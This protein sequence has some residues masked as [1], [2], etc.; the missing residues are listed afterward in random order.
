MEKKIKIKWCNR[1]SS[2]IEDDDMGRWAR[3]AYAGKLD[4]F[5]FYRNR[6]SY[7]EIAWISKLRYKNKIKFLITYRFPQ[8]DNQYTFDNLNDAKK[9]VAKSFN[10]FI[11]MVNKNA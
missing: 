5:G 11:K 6:V 1:Y 2:T 4:C 3:V 9:Q 7:F 8:A 10:W